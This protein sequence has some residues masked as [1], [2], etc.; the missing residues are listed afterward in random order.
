MYEF[1][2]I[3]YKGEELQNLQ[4]YF[5]KKELEQSIGRARL[6]RKDCQ[7]VVLSNF[8]CEQAELNQDDYLEIIES[9]VEDACSPDM[10]GKL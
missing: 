10:A 6:L 2:L 5:I 7:V 1:V 8:P 4:I 9:E 3:T